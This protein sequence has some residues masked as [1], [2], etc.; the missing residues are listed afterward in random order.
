MA[1]SETAFLQQGGQSK[2]K[3][4]FFRYH[5]LFSPGV[6]LIRD[7]KFQSQALLVAFA[8]FLPLLIVLGFVATAARND[9]VALGG[10]HR[11]LAGQRA[12][13]ELSR[14]TQNM[15]HAAVLDR[16]DLAE[17]QRTMQLAFD[18]LQV[19]LAEVGAAQDLRQLFESFSARHHALMQ[20]PVAASPDLTMTAYNDYLTALTLLAGEW[21][22][23]SGLAH[24]SGASSRHFASVL[25]TSG[26]HRLENTA[27]LYTLGTLILASKDLSPQRRAW[28]IE[29]FALQPYFASE[30]KYALDQA[31]LGEAAVA[32]SLDLVVS[33]AGL[34][35]HE[36]VSNAERITSLM[37]TIAQAT[38]G[39]SVGLGQV[40]LVDV[41]SFFRIDQ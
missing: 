39:Q 2:G 32:R 12:V 31:L 22:Q 13:L 1:V 28:M 7:L 23:S 4:S 20:T 3:A 29:W 35:V 36:I 6:R 15:R 33:Q 5:G 34:T 9:L 10:E 25:T 16:A 19:T 14:V 27:R 8:F 11:A 30:V 17:Q 18:R 40:D 24:D 37:D 38:H 26:L 21:A 41:I